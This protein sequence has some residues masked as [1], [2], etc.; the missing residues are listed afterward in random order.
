MILVLTVTH[1]AFI[2]EPRYH[3]AFI[4]ILCILAAQGVVVVWR[5]LSL[6]PADLAGR[7][8]G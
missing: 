5:R 2:P 4:P 6:G 1:L 3:F 8:D 7:T